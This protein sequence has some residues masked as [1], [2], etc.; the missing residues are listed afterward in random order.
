VCRLD[1]E[2]SSDGLRV[3]AEGDCE[4]LGGVH[5]DGRRDRGG[6]VCSSLKRADGSC[7]RDG[8][9]DRLCQD[10][11]D[12]SLGHADCAGGVW[13]GA[14]GGLGVV[15]GSP[16]GEGWMWLGRGTAGGAA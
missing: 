16:G 4:S 1:R 10:W 13:H 5:G 11:V 14:G 2:R 7:E 3:A 6:R 8:G 9:G 12:V 15:V